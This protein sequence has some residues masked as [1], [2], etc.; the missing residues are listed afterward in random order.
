MP[1]KVTNS[2]K[3]TTTKHLSQHKYLLYKRKLNSE[4]QAALKL[5]MS[6]A[7]VIQPTRVLPEDKK[8]QSDKLQ[9]IPQQQHDR[10]K[11]GYRYGTDWE[12]DWFTMYRQFTNYSRQS[13]AGAPHVDHSYLTKLLTSVKVTPKLA[14]RYHNR[15]TTGENS[16]TKVSNGSKIHTDG[17][18]GSKSH[19]I[20]LDCE[21]E[22]SFPVEPDSSSQQHDQRKSAKREKVSTVMFSDSFI[23]K[24]NLPPPCQPKR[25]LRQHTDSPP[26]LSAS[27]VN[28]K[29]P[30][31]NTKS[32]RRQTKSAPALSCKLP[33][34]E[35]LQAPSPPIP[36]R[37]KSVVSRSLDERQ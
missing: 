33:S 13:E 11:V 27:S 36:P 20:A 6:C 16:H 14:S 17:T 26:K 1:K 9:E 31:L 32:S 18:N 15:H 5:E 37:S 25:M 29:P 4:T 30:T 24:V 22:D 21:T 35:K 3:T 34:T 10:S 8:E 19:N 2:E 28:S 12:K 23:S 7:D